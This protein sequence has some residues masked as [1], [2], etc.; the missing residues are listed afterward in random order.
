MIKTERRS[1]ER[2]DF[3]LSVHAAW[4]DADGNIKE[5][6]GITK[7]ISS[8]GVFM[9]FKNLIDRGREIDFRIDLPV[10]VENAKSRI[11]A[12]G[13]IVRNVSMTHSDTSYGYGIMFENYSFM[14]V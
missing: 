2:Y 1:C 8:S 14:R 12:S 5:E 6:T 9:V 4:K 10:F 3:E 11:M 13:K 7:D